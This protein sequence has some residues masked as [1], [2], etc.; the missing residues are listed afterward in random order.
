M[1]AITLLFLE[2]GLNNGQHS[3]TAEL[4]S[5]SNNGPTCIREKVTFIC[6]IFGSQLF[7]YINDNLVKH[8]NGNDICG[9]YEPRPAPQELEELEV[10]A[11]LARNYNDT[12][13]FFNCTSL[14]DIT[15]TTALKA[16]VT[17]STHNPSNTNAELTSDTLNFEVLGAPPIPENPTANCIGETRDVYNALW[18][19]NIDENYVKNITINVMNENGAAVRSYVVHPSTSMSLI[20]VENENDIVTVTTYNKCD[21]SSSANV[22]LMTIC[23]VPS[24]TCSAPS[25][26]YSAPLPTCSAP[27]PTCS[28]TSTIRPVKTMMMTMM[29]I[30]M[31]IS[32]N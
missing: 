8:Y 31:Y 17:C 9:I 13:D 26:T 7:W 12:I 6:N 29:I 28:A 20:Q 4:L 32:T 23:S 22:T 27:T 1:V 24:P 15:S 18:N 14:L 19:Q 5:T 2:F 10:F 11:L 30:I 16:N 21:L 25:P 3:P